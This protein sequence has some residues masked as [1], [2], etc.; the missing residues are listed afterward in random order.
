M[1]EQNKNKKQPKNTRIEGVN[2]GVKVIDNNIEFA[3]KVFKRV[4][5]DSKK[6]ETYRERQEYLKPSVQKRVKKQRAIR[7][8]EQQDDLD[9][10]MYLGS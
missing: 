4:M 5:R 8:Q 10:Q 6:I 2:I 3:L 1:K 7:R 9:R